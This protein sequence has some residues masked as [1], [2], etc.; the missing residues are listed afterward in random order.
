MNTYILL[1]T[2][3]LFHRSR[4][5]VRGDADI[6]IGMS[7]HIM[8]HSIRKAWQDFNGTH[9]IFALEGRSWRKSVYPQYKANRVVDK[10]TLTESEIEE[11]EVFWETYNNF[12]DYIREKTNCTVLQNSQLEADDLIAGFIQSHPNDNH[13]IISTDTD[14]VQLIS[15][16]VKQYNGVTETLITDTGYFDN[17]GKPIID[18]KT[19]IPKPI[20]NPEWLLFE[21]CMRGDSTDNVFSAYPGVRAKSSKN[22]IGLTEAFEDREKMGYSWNNLMLQKWI[23]HHDIEHR[24]ID[25]Y[26]RNRM[27]IDLTAQPS[28]IRTL[29]DQTIVESCIPKNVDQVGIKLLKFCQLYQLL[30]IS[31]QAQSYSIP[32]NEKYK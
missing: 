2:S 24:V 3:N 20:P 29:I 21:K 18:N 28:E 23:D 10:S 16:N 6:K 14:F 13:V 5:A 17:K 26:N 31:E 27:L 25:D 8:F 1:D 9:V 22:K 7:L 19:K 15:P 12:T 11:N 32:L 30:K 4:H